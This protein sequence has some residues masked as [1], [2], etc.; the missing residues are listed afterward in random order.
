MW[1]SDLSINRKSRHSELGV[2]RTL[3]IHFGDLL[4]D[5]LLKQLMSFS[6][7]DVG[8]FSVNAADGAACHCKVFCCKFVF[9]IG[10]DIIY[11]VKA[12][13]DAQPL[14]FDC[15]YLERILS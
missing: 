11:L 8:G 10:V 3:R 1:S 6:I 4:T 7:W 2:V 12:F 13:T 5:F 14:L 15:W 9:V